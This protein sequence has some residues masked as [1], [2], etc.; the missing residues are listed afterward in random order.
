MPRHLLWVV[1]HPPFV[2]R[3]RFVASLSMRAYVRESQREATGL[4]T[5]LD[6]CGQLGCFQANA[7]AVAV[8]GKDRGGLGQSQQAGGN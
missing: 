1:G 5:A 4:V 2:Y 3:A 7:G 8:A 6:P